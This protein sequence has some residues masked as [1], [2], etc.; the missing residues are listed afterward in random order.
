MPRAFLKQT[1]MPSAKTLERGRVFFKQQA[2][3]CRSLARSFPEMEESAQKF[4]RWSSLPDVM[5]SYHWPLARA[6]VLRRALVRKE[7]RESKAEAL[8]YAQSVDPQ[9]VH[10]ALSRIRMYRAY[11]QDVEKYLLDIPSEDPLAIWDQSEE[12]ILT[13]RE[14]LPIGVDE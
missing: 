2:I 3:E 7:M 12:D 14:L 6:E 1:E 4:E 13:L 5:L 11:Q 9:D 10:K 8:T